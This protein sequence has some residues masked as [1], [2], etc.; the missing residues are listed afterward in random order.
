M[1]LDFSS[2]ETAHSVNK[3]NRQKIIREKN[4]ST[5]EKKIMTFVKIVLV[6]VE[7]NHSPFVLDSVS[8]WY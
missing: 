7:G 6:H 4:Y 8:G 3:L 5:Y 1:K 2:L